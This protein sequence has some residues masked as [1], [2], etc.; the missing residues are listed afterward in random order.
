MLYPIDTP[1]RTT[2]DLSGIWRFKV[3]DEK[4]DF[5]PDQVLTDSLSLAVPAS[6][7]DQVSIDAIRNHVGY[8]WYQTD[9]QL[10]HLI[11]A[12]RKVLRFGSA[13]HEAWVYLNG[14]E[15]GH[16]K[17]GFTPFEMDITDIA[18]AGNNR[19]TVRLSNMLDHTTLPVGNYSETTDAHGRL[20]RQVDE[21]FDFYNYA[22]IHRPVILYTTHK[23]YIDDIAINPQLNED[24]SKAQINIAVKT[25]Q[26]DQH[27]VLIELFDE[28]DQLVASGDLNE[29]LVIENPQL[30]Q[31]MKAYLYTAKVSLKDGSDILDSYSEP[32]GI[33]SVEVKE[34][35]FLINGKPFYFKGFGKHEDTHIHGRGLDN[36]AN[37]LDIQLMKRIG[38]NS[39]RTSHYPYSEEM[40]RLCDREGIVVIDE[41]TG[42]GIMESFNFDV[43]ILEDGNF[44]DAT[45]TSLDTTAA[46]E[47]VIRELI[48]RDKN[49]ACVVMWSIANEAATYSPGALEYFTPLFELARELDPQKRPLTLIHIMMS[50]P[51]TDLVSSLV[52]VICLNRYYGWYV[53][54]GDLDTAEAQTRGEL[55]AWQEKYPEKPIMYTEYGADTVAGLHSMEAA[56]FTE[57]FQEDYYAM[58]HRVF[59][60]F[61]NFVG[62]QLWN[63]ADF[64]TKIGINRVQGNKKGIFTR[65]RQPKMTVRSI[66]ERWN[67]I[68][69]FDYKA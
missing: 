41:T 31:P 59:D 18:V 11:A 44:N 68:P 67:H 43:S 35:K 45:F 47:Q 22:G 14:Q 8:F 42:V 64:A 39:I 4:G 52:D 53:S 25:H 40:M 62:E 12:E 16:H 60:E 1:T 51:Q 17:G 6:F 15:I 29:A 34:G 10:P 55:L 36:A 49:H 24:F 5:T 23:H 26:L 30:W 3:D 48:T 65:D 37:V 46:H 9:F 2:K 33:R 66:S 32:F 63:F 13:T 7:N 38:A 56:P 58:N 57:E 50:N 21:N 19:L 27:Q 61:D 28:E 20:V 54:H 69:N